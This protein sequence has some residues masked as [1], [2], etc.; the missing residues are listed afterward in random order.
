MSRL[1]RPAALSFAAAGL[2]ALA[3]GGLLA[4]SLQARLREDGFQS[5]VRAVRD[6]PRGQLSAEDQASIIYIREG[7]Q[8]SRDIN[9]LFEAAWQAQV[10]RDAAE[11]QKQALRATDLLIDRHG[12]P[13]AS[14]EPGIYQDEQFSRL[15]GQFAEEGS[16]SLPA[17][18]AAAA[19]LEELNILDLQTRMAQTEKADIR[20]VYQHLLKIASANLWSFSRAIERFGGAAYEPRY[21]TPLAFS[22]LMASA[23]QP[24]EGSWLLR[25]RERDCG[26]QYLDTISRHWPSSGTAPQALRSRRCTTE[27]DVFAQP[28]TAVHLSQGPVELK[29]YAAGPAQFPAGV[30]SNSPAFWRDGLLHVINSDPAGAHLSRGENADS[31]ADPVPVELP[32]PQRPGMVWMEAVW[33]DPESD[34]LYGW[35]HFEPADLPCPERTAPIIGAAVSKDGGLTWEDRGFVLENGYPEDC[36]Y[37]IDWFVGGNGDFSVVLDRESGYFYFL[38]SNYIGA[39]EEMGVGVARSAFDD[40]GQPGTVWKYYRG[41]WDEPGLGGRAT[42]VFR[43][44]TGWQG[45]NIDAFWGPSV[46]WNEYLGT[47]VVLLNRAKDANWGQDG[48]YIA[49]SRDVVNWTEPEKIF[50]ANDWYPQVIGLGQAG[51]DSLAG[52]FMRVYVGGLSTFILEFAR[53]PS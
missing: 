29:I 40:R 21:L 2:V 33:Q 27:V 24:G 43:S 3:L 31:L 12:L 32:V 41:A 10:F 28:V 25:P 4:F 48:I 51:T 17:A 45:P 8:L 23:G 42:A 47:Y 26:K 6:S 9:L 11:R 46:H 38:F 16:A 19:V 30:D 37:Q 14:A 44:S 50:E 34:L 52:R 1:V 35:Y 7:A 53:V 5:L 39:P 36:S 13:A 15:Y 20:L 49:F 22:E 18:L